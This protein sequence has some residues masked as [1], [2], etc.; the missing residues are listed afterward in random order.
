M[1]GVI[2]EMFAAL[3]HHSDGTRENGGGIQCGPV[4]DHAFHCAG[5]DV[6]SNTQE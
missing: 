4:I 6:A 5:A 2:F 3:P 1:V